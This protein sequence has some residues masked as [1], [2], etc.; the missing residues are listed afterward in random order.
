MI[1]RSFKIS[2]SDG[3]TI[4][5]NLES[6]DNRGNRMESM[7]HWRYLMNMIIII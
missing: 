1:E 6:L 2:L 7:D 3:S 4:I 5:G